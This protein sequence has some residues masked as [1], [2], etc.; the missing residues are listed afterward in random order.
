M[1]I[2]YLRLVQARAFGWIVPVL[3]EHLAPD[4]VLSL[5]FRLMVPGWWL[6][7]ISF[8]LA[9]LAL[10]W[11]EPGPLSGLPTLLMG[12]SV[13]GLYM[14]LAGKMACLLAPVGR[15]LVAAHWLAYLL[16]PVALVL[17][18]RA[19][20]CLSPA[21]V[22]ASSVLFLAFVYH[23]ARHFAWTAILGR[24]WLVLVAYGLALLGL[25]STVGSCSPSAA[26]D[27]VALASMLLLYAGLW[28]Y[29]GCLTRASRTLRQT[30]R[31]LRLRSL[32]RDM[33]T[34]LRQQFH[35]ITD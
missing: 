19:D 25:L 32:G 26:V 17:N 7:M 31:P 2:N 29:C 15:R 11:S 1:V 3:R 24:L 28:L 22:G 6:T 30:A 9:T 33:L 4:D 10:A 27:A 34:A 5:G 20:D 18:P 12:F 16:L 35:T 23:L 13:L 21:L 14:I 8:P